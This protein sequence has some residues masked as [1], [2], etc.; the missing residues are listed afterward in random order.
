VFASLGIRTVLAPQIGF[1]PNL[2]LSG[3]PFLNGYVTK[4]TSEQTTISN[5]YVMSA[6]KSVTKVI[7]PRRGMYTETS[8]LAT[9]HIAFDAGNSRWY[10]SIPNVGA[11][12]D[13]DFELPLDMPNGVTLQNIKI[14]WFQSSANGTAALYKFAKTGA[15]TLVG[16]SQIIAGAGSWQ[17]SQALWSS[18]AESIALDTNYYALVINANSGELRVASVELDYDVTDIGLA[19]AEGG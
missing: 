1:T 4:Y 13:P 19:A 12:V 6:A 9:T 16:S 17:D 14:T 10:I 11:G 5:A 8:G 3:L 7:D 15:R 2:G 18:L